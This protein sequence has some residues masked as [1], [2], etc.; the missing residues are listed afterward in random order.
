MDNVKENMDCNGR[1]SNGKFVKGHGGY[2]KAGLPEMQRATRE[3]L[4]SFFE[5]KIQ[6]LPAIFEKLKERDQAKILL[7]LAEFFLPR[8]K[9]VYVEGNIEQHGPQI[10]YSKLS[11]ATLREIIAA[12]TINENETTL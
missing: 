8:Q 10:D 9:E 12:T 3:K 5:E 11:E 1:A 6:K 4:W 7:S 2:K